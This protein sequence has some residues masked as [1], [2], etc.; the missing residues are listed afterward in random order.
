V[1]LLGPKRLKLLLQIFRVLNLHLDFDLVCKC[2]LLLSLLLQFLTVL[3]FLVRQ[4]LEHFLLLQ[5]I[6]LLL[7][8]CSV[9]DFAV[10]VLHVLRNAHVLL[11]CL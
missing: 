11:L 5:S 3:V 7:F 6:G 1:F 8:D 9:V 4:S 10:I 2:Q